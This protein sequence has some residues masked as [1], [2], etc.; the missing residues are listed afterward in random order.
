LFE[1]DGNEKNIFHFL[2]WYGE[3]FFLPTEIMGRAGGSSRLMALR[4]RIWSLLC[5]SGAVVAPV[6]GMGFFSDFLKSETVSQLLCGVLFFCLSGVACHFWKRANQA[7]QG[8]TAEERVGRELEIL[9]A[10]GWDVYHDIRLRYWGNADHFAAA[11]GGVYFCI[12]TKGFD[13]KIVGHNQQLYRQYGSKL[14][15]L[16]GRKNLLKAVKGQ[17]AELRK[18][19]GVGWVNPVLCFEGSTIDPN[20]LNT[21]VDGVLMGI[22]LSRDKL[23]RGLSGHFGF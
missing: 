19:Q 12:D 3:L 8:A 5:F 23:Y 10:Y 22:N 11:P 6:K 21:I 9:K 13:G 2:L 18:L 7:N 15:P 17:A 20:I 16:L 1:I 4:R 14:Y